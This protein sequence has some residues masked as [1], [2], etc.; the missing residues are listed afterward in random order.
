MENNNKNKNNNNNNNKNNNIIKNLNKDEDEEGFLI[1]SLSSNNIPIIT[2]DILEEG[3][4]VV[5]D[6][7]C[8]IAIAFQHICQYRCRD[9]ILKFK[10][11][12]ENQYETGWILCN[13]GKAYL[14]L[15]DYP[16]GKQI[17]EKVQ[18]LE[19]YRTEGMEF[20]STILWYMRQVCI[21]IVITFYFI[22]FYFLFFSKF[23]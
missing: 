5:L 3:S 13:V 7:L 19:P 21:F 10:E 18:K 14:E 15:A 4:K 1:P 23:L 9:A 16:A 6:I 11:L 17:Y 12:P 8:I 2:N 20:Y 22:K